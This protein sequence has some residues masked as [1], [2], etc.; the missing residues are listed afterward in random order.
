MAAALSSVT[1]KPT[2]P[3]AANWQ[4]VQDVLWWLL[5]TDWLL[6]IVS[7]VLWTTAWPQPIGLP[8]TPCH[9]ASMRNGWRLEATVLERIWLR[10]FNSGAGCR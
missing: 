3:Y 4:M 10:W 5:T 8:V 6:S 9:F 7:H 2:T 1:L